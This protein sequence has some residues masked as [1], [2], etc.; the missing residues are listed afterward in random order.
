MID[1]SSDSWG[2]SGNNVTFAANGS[3]VTDRHG[4]EPAEEPTR[5]EERYA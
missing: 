1:W 3:W 5:G 4:E 2:E